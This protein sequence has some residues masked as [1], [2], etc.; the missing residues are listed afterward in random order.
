MH[1][2]LRLIQDSLAR[3]H[4]LHKSDPR[5]DA[6]V[7]CRRPWPCTTVQ[8][9]DTASW[10][11]TEEEHERSTPALAQ[12]LSAVERRLHEEGPRAQVLIQ[13]L[14]ELVLAPGIVVE[15]H[16]H[17]GFEYTVSYRPVGGS[18]RAL[19]SLII[20]APLQ[21]NI[22][23]PVDSLH[24]HNFLTGALMQSFG[25]RDADEIV[26]WWD[27][28]ETANDRALLLRITDHAPIINSLTAL[29]A[30]TRQFASRVA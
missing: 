14:H 29:I 15:G 17:W 2:D 26:N 16:R 24:S 3:I 1:V 27:C 28:N 5:H 23:A 22:Y 9:A 12:V 4:S 8:A 10:A 21:I 7:E 6:C 11:F 25:P 19:W 18:A 13:Q 20:S 30:A